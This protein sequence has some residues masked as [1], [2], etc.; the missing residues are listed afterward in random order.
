[1]ITLQLTLTAQFITISAPAC[2]SWN[3]N[4]IFNSLQHFHLIYLTQ[5]LR[6]NEYFNF[7]QR[8]HLNF[9]Q[10]SIFT[11]ILSSFTNYFHCQFNFFLYFHNFKS[12]KHPS[13]LQI[14]LQFKLFLSLHL[15]VLYP[16]DT[17]TIWK[18]KYATITHCLCANL[19]L[20]AS[21]FLSNRTSTDNWVLFDVCM[22][23]SAVPCIFSP[24]LMVIVILIAL[25]MTSTC[26]SNQ[27]WFEY[28]N[29]SDKHPTAAICDGVAHWQNYTLNT[30]G[31]VQ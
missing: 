7:I 30:K 29:F 17:F 2:Q 20:Y 13:F 21:C 27:T 19:F 12:L 31:I 18:T 28:T 9:F 6:W 8:L 1:M 4:W 11:A 14:I 10:R 23:L 15:I 3:F 5:R 24:W 25:S 26:A 16:S 22:S